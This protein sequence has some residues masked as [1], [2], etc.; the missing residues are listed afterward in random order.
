MTTE[1]WGRLLERPETL[2]NFDEEADHAPDE[3]I[4]RFVR[5]D[6][7]AIAFVEVC[8]DKAGPWALWRVEC[9]TAG[10]GVTMLLTARCTEAEAKA[11]LRK[12]GVS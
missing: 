7:G 1:F 11:E 5:M 9:L 4:R 3:Y 2:R 10:E 12:L 6:A 8:T